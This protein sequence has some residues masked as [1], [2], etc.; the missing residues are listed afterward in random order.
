MRLLRTHQGW[1][2]LI[3]ID[4]QKNIPAPISRHA[5]GH[6][7]FVRTRMMWE[8]GPDQSVSGIS[9]ECGIPSG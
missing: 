6:V 3:S 2:G 9:K 8:H 1:S 4:R 7:R 5:R